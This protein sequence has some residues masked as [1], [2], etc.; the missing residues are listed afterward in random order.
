MLWALVR[1]TDRRD[2]QGRW[3]P[4]PIFPVGRIVVIAARLGGLPSAAKAPGLPIVFEDRKV[5][6][7]DII[8]HDRKDLRSPMRNQSAGSTVSSISIVIVTVRRAR[9]VS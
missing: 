1:S 9:L 6:P 2:L 4:H 8:V 3:E 5:G 7:P